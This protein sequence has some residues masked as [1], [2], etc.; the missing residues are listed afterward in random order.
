[1]QS[2]SLFSIFVF[3][4]VLLF[5]IW[6]GVSIVTDQ[7]ETL[8]FIVGAAVLITCVLLGPKI[9]LILPFASALGLS[10]MIPGQPNTLLLAQALFIGFCGLQFLM[11]RLPF[12]FRI[13]EL[14]IWVI[15]LTLCL[16]QAYLRNPVGLNILGGES[17]G[18]RPYAIYTIS[19]TSSLILGSL[20]VS[21]SDLRWLLRLSILGGMINFTISTI[22]YFIPQ[23]GVWFG[24]ASLNTLT[25]SDQQNM[26]YQVERASRIVFIATAGKNIALWLSAYKSPIKACFHPLWAPLILLSIAL[27]ALS[28]YR[29]EIVAIGMIYLLGIAYQGGFHSSLIAILGL[30]CGI[31]ILAFANMAFPLPTNIQRSLSFLPGTWDEV[32]AEEADNSTQWR[33]DMWEAALLTD[34]WISNKLVGDGLGMTEHEYNFIQ[35]S[36][37]KQVGGQSGTGKLTLDQQ[38]MMAAGN[39][40]SG[41][42]STIRSI[43]YIGLII[44]LLSQIRLAVHAHRL[45]RRAT[46]SSW[47]PLTLF[48]GIPIISAPFFFVFVFGD[49]K[50]GIS[51]FLMSAGI[52]RLLENNLGA[53]LAKRQKIA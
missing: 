11:R 52:I 20:I 2:R 14:E 36:R 4:G 32:Q 3:V 46:G 21:Q 22:G 39:Y 43:G 35:S 51:A 47:L 53:V 24:A 16:L 26:E 19:L 29:S 7:T 45:I 44:F 5:S 34:D 25:S 27:V 30:L 23:I 10:L 15:L 41:P 1:M 50:F 42:V 48:I 38:L 37:Q 9:W 8:I 13:T 33:V 17:I 12:K 28:G 18:A 6:I 40:H 49:I 31:C